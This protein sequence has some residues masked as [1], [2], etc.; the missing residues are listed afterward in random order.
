MGGRGCTAP[1]VGA[2]FPLTC[3]YRRGGKRGGGLG[4][5]FD[6]EFIFGDISVYSL[7]ASFCNA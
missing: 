4:C 2:A 3:T 7:T 1:A 5:A 6:A